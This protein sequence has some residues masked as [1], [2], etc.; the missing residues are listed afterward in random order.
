[1]NLLAPRVDPELTRSLIDWAPRNPLLPLGVGQTPGKV[2]TCGDFITQ[3]EFIDTTFYQE[4]W[5]PAGYDTEP[6]TTNLLVDGAASGIFTSYG[7]LNRSPF[8]SGQ[9]RLFAAL[10]QHLVR[11]VALQRRLYR[12][13]S[14]NEGALAS[15]DGL[16]Q[17]FL[18]V[19][20]Q[21]R[22]LFVNR[23][24]RALL[25]AR[26]VLRLEAGTLSASDADAGQTL[27]GLIASCAGEA[28]AAT[29]RGGDIALPRGTARLPL[30]V[31][32]TPIRSETA[33][34]AIPWTFSQHAVAIVLVSD[35]ETEIQA[36]VEDLRERFGFTPAEAAFALEIMKGD[37]RQAT[38]DRLG[39]SVATARSHLT[40]IFDKTGVRRQAEL[41]RLL[42]QK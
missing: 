39:I 26:D 11:A 33:M 5:R 32:V 19:D 17:G 3:D 37:G 36:R 25:D 8:D 12:L 42:L 31:L 4:W 22:L 10:A 23:A 13:T 16:Q 41:V 27:R 9:K 40:K 18:L 30:N 34:A 20:A 28:N 7:L 15:L 29:D 38:A 1:M 21:A 24:A 35:P 6:L 2:F 14:A